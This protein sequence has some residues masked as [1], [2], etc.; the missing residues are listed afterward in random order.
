M[1]TVKAIMCIAIP[2]VFLRT[3]IPDSNIQVELVWISACSNFCS[4]WNIFTASP[5]ASHSWSLPCI[6]WQSTGSA[7]SMTPVF[8]TASFNLNMFSHRGS[9]N[10]S[11]SDQGQSYGLPMREWVVSWRPWKKRDIF[12]HILCVVED[13]FKCRTPHKFSGA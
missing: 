12:Q 2:F 5:S 4:T 11:L 13:E 3:L 8:P 9:P 10:H 1:V 7:L 6:I